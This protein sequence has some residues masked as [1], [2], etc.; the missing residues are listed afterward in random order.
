M[1][2]NDRQLTITTAPSRFAKRWQSST[3][4]WSELIE[5]FKTPIRSRETLDYYLALPKSQ[6]DD[7]KD[8][9]GFVCGTLDGFKRRN[10]TLRTRS[11][12]ALDLDHIPPG[13]AQSVLKALEGLQMAYVAYSTRKHRPEAPRLRV[14][15]PTDREMSPDEY[16]P[17][18][19]WL[20]NAIGLDYA[21][22]TTF[23]AVRLMYWPSACADGEY[24]FQASDRAWLS[25]DGVLALYDDWRDVSQWPRRKNERQHHENQAKTQQDPTTKAGVV[26]AFCRVYDVP[27]A[28]EVYLA[29]RYEPTAYP[30]RYTFLGGSTTGG[31][32][33]YEGGKFLY[34]HHA[35]DPASEQLVNAFDLV[36]L[37]LF[38][39]EDEEAKDGTPTNRLPSF[40]KMLELASADGAVRDLINAEQHQK[41]LEA[42]GE[43]SSEE[44]EPSEGVS[45]DW[46]KKLER[47][48]DG[49]AKS[50]IENIRLILTHHP[51]LADKIAFDEFSNRW[52]LLGAVPWDKS[53]VQRPMTDTDDACIRHFL[54]KGYGITGK[55]RTYDAVAIVATEHQFNAVKSYLDGLEWDGVPRV[56]TLWIDYFGAEDS[57]YIRAV[58]RKFLC[59]AVAR[60][61][62]P[63]VKFDNMPVFSGPQGCGKSTFLAKLGR[64]WHTDSLTSF[65]GKEAA[66]VIQGSWL[67]EVGELN[68][69]NRSEINA[70]KQFLSRTED[71]FRA[72]YGRRTGRYPRRCVFVGTTNDAEYLRDQTG[73]RRFWPVDLDPDRASKCPFVDFTAE[74]VGQVWA[75]AKHLW[76]KGEALYLPRELA[77]AAK[78]AQDAHMEFNPKEGIIADFVAKPVPAHWLQKDI[79]ARRLY[80]AE[81]E[82]GRADFFVEPRDRICALEVWCECFGREPRDFERRHSA[83]IN[84]ILAK[85]P[86]W[87]R[88]S[89]TLK[90]GKSYGDQRGFKNQSL[91]LEVFKN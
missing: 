35:T 73:N 82:Q 1:F 19:R 71:N 28:I 24:L 52:L 29:D 39:E 67:I 51:S 36:R 63:G 47:T 48:E 61:Y 15:A 2:L 62:Q 7:L 77:E 45:L 54:E 17:V 91:A 34:S 90:F 18:A 46:M 25:V 44:A 43:L 74:E 37:H 53:K 8:C 38:A 75:E 42:F 20:A 40:K 87:K 72:A 10:N 65:E 69:M 5:K 50:T 64:Q 83:E 3:L 12:V 22:K 57:A 79:Q 26:G 27:S 23:S 55:E 58:C 11:L 70:V 89:G 60:V 6:Q 13:H 49:R 30:D 59:A 9:G 21:D 14:L 76:K 41:T 33:L 31:A 56:D 66:E 81:V 85:L 80:W 78:E 86:D 4:L 88:Y 16:E 32:V 84:A 68:A